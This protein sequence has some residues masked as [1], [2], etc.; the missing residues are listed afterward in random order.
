VHHSVPH[1]IWVQALPRLLLASY[2]LAMVV[3]LAIRVLFRPGRSYLSW[4]LAK[5]RHARRLK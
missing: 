4:R 2:G 3:A 5:P 1:D